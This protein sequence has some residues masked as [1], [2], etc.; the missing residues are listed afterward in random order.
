MTKNQPDVFNSYVFLVHQSI[1]RIPDGCERLKTLC[2]EGAMEHPESVALLA[3]ACDKAGKGNRLFV[4]FGLGQFK[5]TREQAAEAYK[6]AEGLTVPEA[7]TDVLAKEVAVAYR[8]N[9]LH[10]MGIAKKDEKSGYTVNRNAFVRYFLHR[11]RLVLFGETWMAYN[12]DGHYEAATDV[13][14]GKLVRDMLHGAVK[15]IWRASMGSEILTALQLEVPQVKEFDA[16]RG[17]LNL[18]NGMLNVETGELLPHSPGYLSS[19]RIP[20][21]FDPGALCLRFLQFIEEVTEGDG[22]LAAVLQ[23]ITGYVLTSET[24][25]EKAFL[26]CGSGSNGKSVFAKVLQALVGEDNVSSVPLSRFSQPFGMQPIIGKTL[27]I[28]SE[29][30][31]GSRINTEN[32]KSVVSGDKIS[33]AVKY[34]NDVPYT[35]ICKLVFLVNSLPETSDATYGFFRKILI[36]PF[37]HRFTDAEKDVDLFEKLR[38]EMPGILNWALEGLRRLKGNGFLFS[39][40]KR[41]R[42]GRCGPTRTSRTPFLGLSVIAS[43]VPM[44]SVPQGARFC[45]RTKAGLHAT[46]LTTRAGAASSASGASTGWPSSR[47]AFP[48]LRKRSRAYATLT[49]S[50]SY[51]KPRPRT[52]A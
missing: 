32:L 19:I 40:C 39:A 44:V 3:R 17:L 37:N 50:G 7:E 43:S 31:V 2:V 26:L 20:F 33:V 6:S 5:L 36:V 51:R 42:S 16:D 52:A 23:E 10:Q 11:V 49:A 41:R 47:A 12:R 46:G 4:C 13:L 30:E 28:A 25:A 24:R 15:D 27:N 45:P 9:M 48:M 21:A 8:A 14:I 34:Q 35:P 22:Q 1:V 38:A 18:E 29:N